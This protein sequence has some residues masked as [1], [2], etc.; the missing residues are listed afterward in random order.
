MRKISFI[1]AMV[2]ML[3]TLTVAANEDVEVLSTYQSK[4]QTTQGTGGWF[5]TAF[6]E[7]GKEELEYFS[8]NARWKLKG[9]EEAYPTV[10]HDLMLPGNDVACGYVFIAPEKG[11]VRLA[12]DVSLNKASVTVSILAENGQEILWEE[13][14]DARDTKD[15]KLTQSYSVI[16]EVKA[17]EEIWFKADSNGANSNDFVTWWP[18]VE[19]TDME[20]IPI[21]NIVTEYGYKEAFSAEGQIADDNWSLQYNKTENY[22]EYK[23][24]MWS[25]ADE[26]YIVRSLSGVGAI[27]D[28][29]KLSPGDECSVAAVWTAP[30]SGV[31]RLTPD[32]AI[33]TADG[34][35]ACIKIVKMNIENN[36]EDI[37]FEATTD[38]D[39]NYDI[40]LPVTRGDK[41]YFEV[42]K[43]RSSQTE[44]L[45]NPQID[46]IQSTI[47][48]IGG[49]LLINTQN[50]EEDDT[51]HCTFKDE[52]IISEE[53]MVML[54]VYDDKNCLVDLSEPEYITPDSEGR[55]EFNISTDISFEAVDYSGWKISLMVITMQDGRYFSANISADSYVD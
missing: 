48:S 5:F 35:T 34:D 31:V 43:T 26:G 7:E 15:Q 18:K 47:F 27:A 39:T 38:D 49:K 11:I 8:S 9:G 16:T 28:A 54:A 25:A 30:V 51:V 29:K 22:L 33:A 21:E 24:M 2:F 13:N 20:Y 10:K 17:G 12:G 45:W 52:K 19:Y 42:E 36:K 6:T 23:E 14:L 44:V 55:T 32:G 1:M 4:M 53:A 37:I 3:G 40:N 41:L 46:Y 50:I